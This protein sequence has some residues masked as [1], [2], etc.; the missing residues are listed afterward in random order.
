MKNCLHLSK[1]SFF[2]LAVISVLILVFFPHVSTTSDIR[3]NLKIA[4]TTNPVSTWGELSKTAPQYFYASDV[5]PLARERIEETLVVART[6]WGNYGPL[7][8]WVTGQKTMPSV[9]F[10]SS[11]CNRRS[12]LYQE[13]KFK[14]LNENRN[15]WFEYARSRVANTT[16][17]SKYSILGRTVVDDAVYD[18]HHIDLAEPLGFANVYPRKIGIDQ[19]L[20]F[21]EFFHVVN[22]AHISNGPAK[23]GDENPR[24]AMLGPTW[25][26]EGSAEFMSLRTV[27]ELRASGDLPLYGGLLTSFDFKA[28]M[29]E[30]MDNALK[31]LAENPDLELTNATNFDGAL[32][33]NLGSWAIAYLLHKTGPNALMD[34]F[35]PNLNRLG[36]YENFKQ[37]FGMT[38]LHFLEEFDK[39]TYLDRAMQMQILDS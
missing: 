25:F 15:G 16:K 24:N 3:E 4:P 1:E 34:K 14:C 7:E 29:S 18:F 39:F 22:N 19:V 31:E 17:P 28:E 32:V 2:K 6:I 11:Y 23:N 36:W 12:Q 35:F 9:D 33:Y 21:H 38:P 26:M 5:P 10:I 8:V 37:T 30:N 27:S 20:V 13:D